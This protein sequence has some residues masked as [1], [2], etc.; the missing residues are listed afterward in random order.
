[1]DEIA[2]ST[3]VYVPPDEVYEFLVDF[4]RYA[5]Y[6][7]HLTEV[8]QFGDG[9]P[10]TR[11]QLRFAWWKLTYT[12]ESQVTGV[13]PPHRIDWSITKDIHAEGH[14]R[15]EELDE[16]PDDAPEHTETATRVFF[17]VE[18][19]TRTVSAGD[20]DLPRFVSLG[21]VVGKVRPVLQKEAERIVERIVAD[22][23]GEPRRVE[24]KI[25][26]HPDD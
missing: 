25:H 20:I 5:N 14:W 21:W 13:D 23:E 3:V 1:M 26:N 12:A 15:T 19:D 8:Q 18:Y 17:E 11:Y 2:V 9:S 7:E 4:P 24:L 16:L 22:L 6:S 10:G